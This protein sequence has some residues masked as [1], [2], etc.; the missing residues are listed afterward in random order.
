MNTVNRFYTASTAVTVLTAV[1]VVAAICGEVVAVDEVAEAIQDMYAAIR[2]SEVDSGGGTVH[3]DCDTLAK[4]KY[5]RNSLRRMIDSDDGGD[6]GRCGHPVSKILKVVDVQ[7]EH[8]SSPENNGNIDDGNGVLANHDGRDDSDVNANAQSINRLMERC[9]AIALAKDK[10]K[11]KN[12]IVDEL[13]QDFLD[14]VG[15]RYGRL[16]KSS[17]LWSSPPQPSSVATEFTDTTTMIPAVRISSRR[18]HDRK[19]PVSSATTA[20]TTATVQ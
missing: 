11:S 12:T 14:V 3:L 18:R 10:G 8:Q 1:V 20:T 16:K 2:T 17:T 19:I 4:A 13:E 15:R 9:M 6:A 7:G 5:V